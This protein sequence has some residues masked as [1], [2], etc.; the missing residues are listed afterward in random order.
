MLG[1]G[2][3]L[4][5]ADFVRVA[6]SPLAV[7]LILA[8]QVLLTPLVAMGLS[9]SLDVPSGIA[10]GMLLIA[11]LPGGL[12]S[13]VLTHL[14]RGNVAL[15]VSATAVCSLG[16]LVTTSLV[17]TTFGSTQLRTG[18]SIPVS[19]VLAEIGLCLLAPLA[20]GMALRR[21]YPRRRVQV[22]NLCIRASTVLLACVIVAALAAGRIRPIQYGWQSP[23][24]IV[25]L[26]VIMLW[27]CYATAWLLRLSTDD[28]FTVGIEVVVRNSHLGVLLNATLFPAVGDV[29]ATGGGV[30]YV[31]LLYG[32][33]SLV[34]GG[35]EVLGKRRGWGTFKLANRAN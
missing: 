16:C 14:G 34:V 8:L 10:T 28:R 12:F 5:P 29:A 20:T 30:L 18:F 33:V 15:S 19:H 21:V 4:R 24:A 17:L 26:Q 13:N 23:L 7:L 31:V 27:S 9:W 6:R 3:S 1:M 22:S 2:C 35:I 25:L 32:G 11:A